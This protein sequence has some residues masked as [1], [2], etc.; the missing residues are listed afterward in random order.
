M[1]AETRNVVVGVFHGREQAR[2]A[3]SALKDA[4]FR[5][6]DISVLMPDTGDTRGMGADTEN[7]AGK[8]AATGAIA[9]GILGGLGGFLVG[10]GALAIPVFG[11]II[12]AG[13]FATALAGAAAGAAVGAIAG[14]LVGMGIPKEEAEWYEG[15]FRSGRSL[16]TV[17]ADGRYQE[18]RSILMRHGAY[19][20]QSRDAVGAGAQVTGYSTASA[21]RPATYGTAGRWEDEMPRYRSTWQRRYGT[22]GE[23]WEDHEPSYR[24]GWERSSD[25]RYQGRAWS[26]VE[27]EFRR[28]WESRHPDTPWE[29]AGEAIRDA[30]ERRPG[31]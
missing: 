24:Y 23:R 20:I 4:G 12:A 19:D 28:D 30:W 18:A 2:D 8:G 22:S 10:I 15:E 5:G 27:P 9:G 16:V 7:E 1:T 13:A 3:I 17:R 25:P 11:P 29:R 6:D 31:R 14:A 21:E 26:E